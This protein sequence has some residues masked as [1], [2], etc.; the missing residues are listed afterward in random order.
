MSKLF[1]TLFLLIGTVGFSQNFLVNETF[2]NGSWTFTGS[3]TPNTWAISTCAGNGSTTSGSNALYITDGGA[4][5]SCTGENYGYA[6]ASSGIQQSIA[7]KSISSN[8]LSNLNLSFDY[9]NSCSTD[10]TEL[11]YSLD[12]GISWLKIGGKIGIS[13]SWSTYNTTLPGSLNT[14]SFLIGFRFFCNTI[15]IEGAPI[16]IDNFR[17]TGSLNLINAGLIEL[18]DVTSTLITASNNGQGNGVWSFSSGNGTINNPNA[19]ATAVNSLDYGNNVLVWTLTSDACGVLT[20]TLRVNVYHQPFQASIPN[21]TLFICDAAIWD[22][23]A[24]AV[25][26][27]YGTG[28]WSASTNTQFTDINS[29]LSQA[30]DFS[31]GWNLLKWTISN[32]NCLA[33]VDSVY[34]FKSYQATINQADSVICYTQNNIS[35]TGT[36]IAPETS[37]SWSFL[38]G[39]GIISDANA[40]SVFISSL[41]IGLN[42]IVYS[43]E[44]EHCLK[45]TDT[46]D[47]VV[48]LCDGYNPEFPTVITPNFDGKNDLFA[49]NYLETVYPKCHVSIFNR[50]GS[51]VFESEGYASPW[52]GTNK[53]GEVL[54]MGTYFYKV[55]LNDEEGT[56]YNGSVSIIQ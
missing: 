7:Y 55:E 22:L 56:V 11:I 20:D 54:P 40:D 28:T 30:T 14:S 43:V 32:G 19:Y 33:T 49:I 31:E 21:D 34:I 44:E 6:N 39:D 24:N 26:P 29:P 23:S 12:N 53:K 8:C 1:S 4:S 10:S 25:I 52:D 13:S 41:M 18:C 45:T 50:Y 27:G 37:V 36:P 47:V 38:A 16:A 42:R 46:I 2:E 9:K 15:E 48:S 3:T 51:I 35:L 17:I 5:G